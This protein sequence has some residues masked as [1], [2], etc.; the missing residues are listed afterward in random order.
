MALD[1]FSKQFWSYSLNAVSRGK[2]VIYQGKE[3][4]VT[5]P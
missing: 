3:L 1:Y 4:P 2:Q 5:E